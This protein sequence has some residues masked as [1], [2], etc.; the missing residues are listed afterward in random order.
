MAKPTITIPTWATDTNFASGPKSGLPSRGSAA[1]SAGD[2]A[3]GFVA[4]QGLMSGWLNRLFGEIL[5]WTA[6]LDA[7]PAANLDDIG[8][9]VF[10]TGAD[11]AGVINSNTTLTRAMNYTTLT[12]SAGAVLTTAGCPIHCT[13][14]C[15][16][17]G[18]GSMID[19]S[20]NVGGASGTGGAG[21]AALTGVVLSGGAAGGTQGVGGAGAGAVG[22]A[23]ATSNLAGAGGAGGAGA[24]GSPAGG[25]GGVSTLSNGDVRSLITAL[26]GKIHLVAGDVLLTA[27]AGGGGGADDGGGNPGGGG[28]G[29]GGL[30]VIAAP[31]ITLASGGEI[32]SRGGAGGA[33]AGAGGGG[34]GGEGGRIYLATRSAVTL[35]VGATS[36]GA[37][38]TSA[39]GSAGSNGGTGLVVYLLV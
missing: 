38:G 25:A 2:R 5:N 8:S 29:G 27:G 1:P 33:A 23:S 31:T 32:R 10:G 17:T 16:V 18:A 30:V 35:G 39:T 14:S 12:V 37:G 6:W 24:G 26:T 36:G 19:W 21:G 13:T 3:Q 7:T 34:G 15:T 28:G 20:G 11:G 4:G 9:W 22:G